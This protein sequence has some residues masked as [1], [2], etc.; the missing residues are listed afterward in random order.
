MRAFGTRRSGEFVPNS[1]PPAEEAVESLLKPILKADQE[2]LFSPKALEIIHSEFSR[3]YISSGS[4]EQ[5]G[6][7]LTKLK[8]RFSKRGIPV[9]D[10]TLNSNFMRYPLYAAVFEP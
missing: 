7:I 5:V 10:D 9:S 2:G 8:Q 3:N 1:R 6:V 4:D